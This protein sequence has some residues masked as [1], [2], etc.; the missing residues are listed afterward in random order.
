MRLAGSLLVTLAAAAA[1]AGYWVLAGV[2]LAALAA[3][4]TAR[5]PALG[6]GVADRCVGGFVRLAQV[7]VLAQAFGAYVV[8]AD[9]AFAAAVFAVCVIAAD[10]FGLRL[11][12]LLVK[13]VLG[14]LLL[15][16]AVLVAM[17]LAVAPV[18]NAGGIGKPDVSAIVVAALIMLPF[19]IPEPGERST[20]RALGL[21]LVAVAITGAA[22]LQLGPIRLGLSGTAFRDLLYAADAGQL[23]P[24]LTVIVVVATVPAGFTTFVGARQRFAPP[25]YQTVV[26][27][28]ELLAGVAA[29]FV[30]VSAVLI[31]GGLGAV[32]ELVLRVR[33]R[34]YRGA[35]D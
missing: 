22:L 31:A 12:D 10:F 30:P 19:L 7:V 14:V 8:P 35:H 3:I 24:L 18:T 11:P 26:F 20:L 32:A 17:C 2:V 34:R 6:D 21:G 23:Q 5:L 16:A 25:S 28:G 27:G 1:G 9:S 33:A 29:M 4:G 13:W 15:A